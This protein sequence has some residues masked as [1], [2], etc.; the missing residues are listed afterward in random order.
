MF[1]CKLSECGQGQSPSNKLLAGP[2]PEAWGV[3]SPAKAL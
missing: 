1:R 2:F 3:R